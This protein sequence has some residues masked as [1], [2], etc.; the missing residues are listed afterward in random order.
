MCPT[1]VGHI[2]TRKEAD[3]G[4]ALRSATPE[5]VSRELAGDPTEAR[6]GKFQI[7]LDVS[8]PARWRTRL[9]RE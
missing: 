5:Q 1:C 9:A 4:C 3:N 6:N 2:D 7:A 8:D